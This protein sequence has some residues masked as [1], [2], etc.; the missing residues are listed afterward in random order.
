MQKLPS[1]V[2]KT[3]QKAKQ[4][5]VSLLLLVYKAFWNVHNITQGADMHNTYIIN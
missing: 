5:L 3:K 4:M 2:K 1:K